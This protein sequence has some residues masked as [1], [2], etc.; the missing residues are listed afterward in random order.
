MEERAWQA[1]AVA[2]P[3]DGELTL[4]L[5]G[6]ELAPSVGLRNREA[7][8]GIASPPLRRILMIVDAAAVAVGLLVALFGLVLVT[9]AT[10]T[11]RFLLMLFAILG[12]IAGLV[13]FANGLYRRRICSVRRAEITRIA[14]TAAALAVVSGIVLALPL[15][16][17]Q[18]FLGAL[19]AFGALFAAL[20]TERGVLREWIHSH[21]ADGQFSA[22][23]LVVGG[24]GVSA[25]RLSEFFF[26][27]PVFGFVPRGV[28]D[29]TRGGMSGGRSDLPTLAKSIT[30]AVTEAGATG[31][32]LDASSLTGDELSFATERLSAAGLHV[33]ISSGLRGIDRRRITVSPLADETFLHV[34]PPSL[35]RR[36]EVVKRLLDVAVASLV[37]LLWSPVLVMSGLMIWAQDRGPI[38][39]RQER[40]GHQ[41]ERFHLY[42]LRTMVVDAESQKAELAESRNARGGPLFKMQHDPRVTRFGRFLRAS[43]IDE[44]P[45]LFNVLEGT[46]SIVG[47]RPALPDEVAQFDEGLTARAD[48]KHG[49]TGLWQVEARDLASF[50]LY[51]RY[52]LHYVHNWSVGFDIAILARTGTVVGL[53]TLRSLVP[54]R[55][56]R[57]AA[58]GL[59]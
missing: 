18:A 9:G 40:V 29:L 49:V 2:V 37:L 27:H 12:P 11:P 36:Q 56:R 10:L 42:K 45:Q 58:N 13:L 33:H 52:D 31:V 39:F 55:L 25:E 8:R 26:E 20:A 38:L 53:R 44:L 30:D 34:L 41:G 35:S 7:Q 6:G 46:M 3:L 28:F 17:E 32:V 1:D 24:D 15:T 48:V 47:P 16:P 43:S 22:P 5:A 14:S 59:E 23:I 4:A 57:G 19:L 21:R 51:R 54:G 50:D